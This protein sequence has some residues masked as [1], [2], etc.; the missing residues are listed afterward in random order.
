MEHAARIKEKAKRRLGRHSR[1]WEDTIKIDLKA[2]R[3]EV[4][5]WNNLAQDGTSGCRLSKRQ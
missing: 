2:I 1:S 3:L 4:V 5:D